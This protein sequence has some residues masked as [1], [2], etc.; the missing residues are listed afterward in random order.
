MRI[1][2]AVVGLLTATALLAACAPRPSLTE[3]AFEPIPI[4]RTAWVAPS[5]NTFV[6]DAAREAREDFRSTLAM[7]VREADDENQRGVIFSQY[8]NRATETDFG[9]GGA[10]QRFD[11]GLPGTLAGAFSA[12]GHRREVTQAGGTIV[13]TRAFA[14]GRETTYRDRNGDTCV[15]VGNGRLRDAAQGEA[16]GFD[17]VNHAILCGPADTRSAFVTYVRGGGIA[18]RVARIDGEPKE[19]KLPNIPCPIP[20]LCK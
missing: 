19:L 20:V 6:L 1:V 14:G 2:L 7:E 3:A 4:N 11:R 10:A 16:G 5:S 12:E 18:P 15:M 9:T 13:S 17:F 8:V